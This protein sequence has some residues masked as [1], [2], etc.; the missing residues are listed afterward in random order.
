MD[1]LEHA[2]TVAV[3][4][5]ALDYC[6]GLTAGGKDQRE[7]GLTAM[8]LIMGEAA[9]IARAMGLTAE[10]FQQVAKT[11]YEGADELARRMLA[12]KP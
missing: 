7:A 5:A 11:L 4:K 10:G 8:G 2:A 1:N 6:D 9:I 12:E 3:H